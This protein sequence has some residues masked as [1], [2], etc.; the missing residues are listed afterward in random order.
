MIERGAIISHV[1]G[2]FAVRRLHGFDESG[3]FAVN[4]RFSAEATHAFAPGEVGR[5]GI[6]DVADMIDDDTEAR[7][8]AGETHGSG[9]IAEAID[10][11]C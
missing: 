7:E 2:R 8:V 5:G 1:R 10:I 9:E 3:E 4:V 11:Y 6:T